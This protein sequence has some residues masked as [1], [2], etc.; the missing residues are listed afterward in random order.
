MKITVLTLLLSMA[1]LSSCATEFPVNNVHEYPQPTNTDIST[2]EP[3]DETTPTVAK[4]TSSDSSTTRI[5]EISL[6]QLE[7]QKYAYELGM[8]PKKSLS[9]E[10]KLQIL[11]RKKLRQ[12][13]RALDT[14]KE[15]VQ[16]SKVLPW[17]QSDDEKI[18]MLTIPS[19]E[20]RQV[21]VN[22]N[23]IWSRAKD[24]KSFDEALEYQDIAV[25]MPID[26]VKKS[27]GEPNHIEVSG[28]P[29]YKNERWQYI[30]QV[31]TTH[32]YKQEKRYVYFEGGRVVGWE[33]E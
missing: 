13:E 25:G 18:E 11:N 4:T 31:S 32:G 22:Q 21:W 26:Y 30:K 29:I 2:N 10:Q 5:E 23:K 20:G 3:S 28:N 16:Y 19:I 27:W 9:D 7:L 15:R 1:L 33:T 17:L 12:L 6:N 14:Q 24:L 8:D